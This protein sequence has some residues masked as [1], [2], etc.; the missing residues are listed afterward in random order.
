[1]YNVNQPNCVTLVL[2]QTGTSPH[3][4]SVTWFTVWPLLSVTYENTKYSYSH[5]FELQALLI[6]F[7]QWLVDTNQKSFKRA[8]DN[9]WVNWRSHVEIHVDWENNWYS[10][11]RMLL[12]GKVPPE[13]CTFSRLLVYERVGKSR[14][15]LGL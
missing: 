4:A 13:R 3:D 12:Y 7:Y 5:M 9:I 8:R 6:Y 14:C 15:H 2:M 1:M 10:Q 11:G